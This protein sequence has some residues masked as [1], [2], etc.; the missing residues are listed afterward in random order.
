MPY[1]VRLTKHTG[2]YR[3]TIPRELIKS[4]GYEDVEFVELKDLGCTGIL[5]REYYGKRQGKRDIPKDKYG[6]D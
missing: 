1:H 2:Q 3:V 4:L 5:L 6:S